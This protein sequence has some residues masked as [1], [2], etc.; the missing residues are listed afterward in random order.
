[1]KIE[2]KKHGKVAQFYSTFYRVSHRCCE[3]G[4]GS[5]K[6]DGGG[7]LSQCKERA[8]GGGVKMLSKNTCEGIHLIVK[9]LAISLQA[10]KFTKNELHTFFIDFS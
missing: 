7:G 9:L 10:C 8:W 3:H 6:C 4:G 5:S 2:G 1:M